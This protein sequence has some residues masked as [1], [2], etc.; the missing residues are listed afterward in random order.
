MLN[1][2]DTQI[3]QYYNSMSRPS[4]VMLNCENCK[5]LFFTSHRNAIKKHDAKLPLL[6]NRCNNITGG[7]RTLHIEQVLITNRGMIYEGNN[8]KVANNSNK[9]F[10]GQLVGIDKNYNRLEVYKDGSAIYIPLENI[11]EV[12]RISEEDGEINM[13]TVYIMVFVDSE[14]E[15]YYFKNDFD[16]KQFKSGFVDYYIVVK[17]NIIKQDSFNNRNTGKRFSDHYD[18]ENW[19]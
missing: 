14:E 3:E 6:C 5:R 7:A 16:D 17:N 15:W 12:A 13:L 2:D 11:K 19:K 18:T 4:D 9:V 8:V 1:N 10:T